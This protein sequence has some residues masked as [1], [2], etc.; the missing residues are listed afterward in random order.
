[1]RC[2]PELAS[3]GIGGG[4]IPAVGP[5]GVGDFAGSLPV[6]DSASIASGGNVGEG[7]NA[8]AVAVG[9]IVRSSSLHPTDSTNRTSK[10]P[11]VISFMAIQ[12]Q[13]PVRVHL[14]G[15]VHSRNPSS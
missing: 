14:L 6:P 5:D 13:D 3:A 9:E 10:I 12:S 2:Y 11:K 15:Y 7:T 4:A 8:V 1:M